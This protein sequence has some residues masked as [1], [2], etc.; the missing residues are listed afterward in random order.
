MRTT[1]LLPILL[2][3][4][5]AMAS[6]GSDSG[7]TSNTDAPL[8]TDAP[9]T[10]SAPTTPGTDAAAVSTASVAVATD[11]A[12]GDHLVDGDGRTLY[13]FEKDS[14]T[15]TACTGD[16]P[17][18]WPPLIADGAPTGGRSGLARRGQRPPGRAVDAPAPGSGP[19]G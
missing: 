17:S 18:N 12:L 2:T 10:G 1:A 11:A 6:C 9:V 16:C 13:L 3:A 5:L 7:S 4:G 14:G 8:T 15:T 19:Q